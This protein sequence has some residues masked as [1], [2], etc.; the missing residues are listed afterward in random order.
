M[1]WRSRFGRAEHFPKAQRTIE[2][3]RAVDITRE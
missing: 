2:C 1:D 3:C